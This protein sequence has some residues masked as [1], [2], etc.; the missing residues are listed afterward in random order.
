[1]GWR[2]RWVTCALSAATVALQFDAD[3]AE[4]LDEL[5]GQ[6][7]ARG[8]GVA[9]A[10]AEQRLGAAQVDA[11]RVLPNP[12]L[13]VSHQRGLTGPTD[14]ET[15]VGL[16]VPLGIGGK[17]SI[18]QD[19]A[20]AREMQARADARTTMFEGAVAFRE[21]YLVA[22]ADASRLR[23]AEAQQAALE[24]L[25]D[26]VRRLKQGGETAGYDLLRQE[27]Q[28][29]LHAQSVGLLRA[30]ADGSRR[31]LAAWLGRDVALPT[32]GL[33]M[34][35]ASD[36]RVD[37]LASAAHPRLESLRASAK[38][39]ALEAGA[40]RRSWVPEL[41]LFGGY[42]LTDL[43]DAA[44]HGI[45]LGLSAPL[46][47]FDRG[48]GAAGRLDAETTLARSM[49]DALAREQAALSSAARAELALLL[50]H[51]AEAHQLVEA[52]DQVKLRAEQLY[53]AGEG[54][55]T[56]LLEAYRSAEEARF[57]AIEVDEQVAGV[58]LALNRAHG[59]FFD[60]SLDRQCGAKAGAG[61]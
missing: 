13:S 37:A 60:A 3:A 9:I 39:S 20:R 33:S 26:L 24:R 31:R 18:L 54:S 1:M 27:T 11:A 7:C 61:W 5:T 41:E 57:R 21:A 2:H 43:G 36:L 49:A 4:T 30:R 44:G 52:T 6:V 58:R 53:A 29:K 10:R 12:T 48:Q 40:A 42:R 32:E 23:A 34:L 16:S 47:L 8:P 28:T 51:V 50:P 25:S 46:T 35:P 55:I 45:S 17:R 56:E 22:V 38:A 19:A 14:R 59:S 15:I